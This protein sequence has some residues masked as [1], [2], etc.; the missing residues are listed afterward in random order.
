MIRWIGFSFIALAA[1]GLVIAAIDQ[2]D[3]R[4]KFTRCVS[5]TG[6]SFRNR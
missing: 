5:I 3:F 4:A 6:S 2:V 1:I